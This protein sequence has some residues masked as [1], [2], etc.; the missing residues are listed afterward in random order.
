MYI[1]IY[2][3]FIIRC[4]CLYGLY[5]IGDLHQEIN[6]RREENNAYRLEEI[7]E[8][9]IKISE[10]VLYCHRKVI[11]Q[12][13]GIIH[14]DLKPENILLVEGEPKIGDF[15]I[16]DTVAKTT[17]M[18][19]PRGWT[20]CYTAP[21]IIKN[22]HKIRFQGDIWSLGCIF[23]ELCTLKKAY[24]NDYIENQKVDYSALTNY[25]PQI[26][27]LITNMLQISPDF[28][29]PINSVLGNSLVII[30]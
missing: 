19:K 8:M 13:R 28:R 30:S 9:M 11:G 23:Y 20:K 26:R 7:I 10:G 16:S 25:P 24:P 12:I 5:D 29:P 22:R 15:G 6:K 27:Q 4:I 14:E 21:E 3:S 18:K 17:E 2:I 1:Y